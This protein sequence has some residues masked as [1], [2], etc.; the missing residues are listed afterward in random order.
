M[1]FC[2]W[3]AQPRCQRLLAFL[4]L[5]VIYVSPV[6]AQTAAEIRETIR[7]RFPAVRQLSTKELADWLADTNK[8]APL[9]IDARTEKEFAVSR[10]QNARHLESVAQV[11]SAATSNAQPIVVYCSVG[12]RSSALAEKL[13]QAGFTHVV[14]LEGSI[15]AW[16]NEGR[17]VYRGTNA[18]HEVHPY[19]SKWGQL[20]DPPLHPKP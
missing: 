16:A 5:G 12:Y 20:L 3:A 2:K 14:N 18:V 8:P 11:K 7:K 17:P 4:T 6:T 19:N 15:F 13:Q 1:N 10:L 9:L